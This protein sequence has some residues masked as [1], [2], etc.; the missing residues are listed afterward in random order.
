M[1]LR[2]NVRSFE[3]HHALL[4]TLKV[5]FKQSCG[6]WKHTVIFLS[7]I[8]LKVVKKAMYK[9]SNVTNIRTAGVCKDV[10][11]DGSVV[12][13]TFWSYTNLIRQRI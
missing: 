11:K 9:D 10:V 1:A 7:A 5:A 3:L 13:Q 4:N 12:R 6:S 8:F 2:E